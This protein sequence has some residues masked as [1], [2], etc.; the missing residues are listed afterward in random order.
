MMQ[1]AIIL[2]PQE[3]QHQLTGVQDNVED[4]ETEL[5]TEEKK[6]QQVTK[7]YKNASKKYNQLKEKQEREERE[8]QQH[9]IKEQEKKLAEQHQQILKWQSLA[10]NNNGQTMGALTPNG[11]AGPGPT[12]H[13][14]QQSNMGQQ[15]QPFTPHGPP[16]QQF[17]PSPRG[18]QGAPM[19]VS[20]V[21]GMSNNNNN[22]NNPSGNMLGSPRQQQQQPQ[23][24]SGTLDAIP[25]EP[26]IFSLDTVQVNHNIADENNVVGVARSPPSIGSGNNAMPITNTLNRA[27]SPDKLRIFSVFLCLGIFVWCFWFLKLLGWLLINQFEFGCLVACG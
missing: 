16:P 13:G 8:K 2:S 12:P 26:S 6:Y 9:L 21:S 22:N 5:K 25:Q 7:Q 10:L 20:N 11:F 1:I 4:A 15:L 19:L 24:P 27:G 18:P 23:A 17:A 14:R 3:L